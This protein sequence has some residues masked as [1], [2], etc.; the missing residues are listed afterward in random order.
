MDLNKFKEIPKLSADLWGNR[1]ILNSL[2]K[3]CRMHM[4]P[5][6]D[7]F[8]VHNATVSRAIHKTAL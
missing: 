1:S 5:I 7:A 4:R 8:G 3:A 6:A 2:K